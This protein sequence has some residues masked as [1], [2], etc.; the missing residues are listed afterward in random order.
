M[1]LLPPPTFLLQPPHS[2]GQLSVCVR[3][4]S[5]SGLCPGYGS[6]SSAEGNTPVR[7][8]QEVPS[9]KQGPLLRPPNP[10]PVIHPNVW[11]GQTAATA[12]SVGPE[13]P[14]A[15]V[16]G[17]EEEKAAAGCLSRAPVPRGPVL[18]SYAPAAAAAAG[19]GVLAPLDQGLDTNAVAVAAGFSGRALH[20]RLRAPAHPGGQAPAGGASRWL[21]VFRAWKPGGAALGSGGQGWLCVWVWLRR[22]SP[23]RGRLE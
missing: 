14:S 21:P 1:D 3:R 10:A 8:G 17:D 5:V 12:R 2:R 4:A 18:L 6:C 15:R 23:P 13:E 7:G 9:L 19:G 20:R 11:P 16:S 22:V